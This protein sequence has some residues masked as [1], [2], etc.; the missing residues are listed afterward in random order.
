[1]KDLEG[2]ERPE[3]GI[4]AIYPN[5]EWLGYGTINGRATEKETC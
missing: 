2:R 1:M 5:N 3:G 4:C